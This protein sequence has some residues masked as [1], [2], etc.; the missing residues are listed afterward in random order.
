MRDPLGLKLPHYVEL[1]SALCLCRKWWSTL[2]AD[3]RPSGTGTVLRV[4]CCRRTETVR[5]KYAFHSERYVGVVAAT[6]LDNLV[7][8][9]QPEQSKLECST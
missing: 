8:R 7:S 6:G 3:A 4:R 1:V 5:I 2:R 9:V